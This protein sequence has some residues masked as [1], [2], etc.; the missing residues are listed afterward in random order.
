[1]LK[2]TYVYEITSVTAPFFA[3]LKMEYDLFQYFF[4]EPHEDGITITIPNDL[5][6]KSYLSEIDLVNL[7]VPIQTKRGISNWGRVEK[8]FQEE[9]GI[10]YQLIF[11]ESLDIQYPIVLDVFDSNSIR[12]QVHKPLRKIFLQAIKDLSLLKQGIK[13]YLNHLEIYFCRVIGYDFEKYEQFRVFFFEDAVKRIAVKSQWIERYYQECVNDPFKEKKFNETDLNQLSHFVETDVN[14]DLINVAF[15]ST[16]HDRYLLAIK[17][18]EEIML[19]N[20]N[21]LVLVYLTPLTQENKIKALYNH[22]AD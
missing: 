12:I 15:S 9:G 1:M 8:I 2:T 16:K 3:T 7:H 22:K 4:K 17:E 6:Y 11:V 21:I 13:V 14:L 10:S 20:Y 5:P 19:F 18:L